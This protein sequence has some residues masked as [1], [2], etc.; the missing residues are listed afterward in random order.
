M[1]DPDLRGKTALV[2][3]GGRG[4]GRATALMLG[5]CGARVVVA[6]RSLHE[7]EAVAAEIADA[8]GSAGAMQCDVSDPVQVRN[9]F[10]TAGGVDIL[11]NNA[12]IIVPIAPVADADP[13]AWSRNI[14]VNL[15]GVFYACHYALPHMLEAGWGRIVNVS[16]GAARGGT[17]TWSAYAAA[18]AGVEAFTRTLANE[19]GDQ[20][21][22]VNSFRPGVVD[23]EMQ[24]EIR[25]TPVEQFGRENYERFHGYK[26][27]GKLRPPEEPAR[28]ILWL[29]TPEAETVNGEVVYI[30]DPEWAEK[31]GLSASRR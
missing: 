2:T 30:D 7:I 20:G 17:T 22:R 15:D 19:V 31:A 11:I 9:L 5:R 1:Q 10:E 6:A 24:V 27:Q 3:G 21:I 25:S 28:L 18:K 14:A 16:S 8:G 29:L 12:G 23:T 13:V 26:E 4:V